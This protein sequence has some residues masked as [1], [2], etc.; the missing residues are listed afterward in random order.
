[1]ELKNKKELLHPDVEAYIIDLEK[2]V[3]QLEFQLAGR[4][5]LLEKL[6]ESVFH[7][8]KVSRWM[9][10]ALEKSKENGT[11]KIDNANLELENSAIKEENSKLWQE[12]DELKNQIWE[13]QQGEDL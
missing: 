7:G 2:C 12:I 13:I 9:E 6:G 4:I 5:E 1:M 8:M 11:L 3:G 10:I